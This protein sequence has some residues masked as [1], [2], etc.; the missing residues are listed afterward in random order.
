M[1]TCLNL[2]LFGSLILLIQSC[3]SVK[4]YYAPGSAAIPSGNNI[5]NASDLKYSLY[6]TGGVSLKGTSPVLKAIEADRQT[7]KSGLVLLG[8]VLSIDELPAPVEGSDASI[9]EEINRIKNLD[10]SFNDLFLIPGQKEWSSEKKV[11]SSAIRLLDRQLKDVR[12]KGRF[13]EPRKGCGTPE[14]VRIT[15]NAI[16]VLVDSQWAIE[17]EARSGEKMNGCELGNVIELKQAIKGIVQSHP[18]DHIIIATHHPIYA[19]G[20]TAGNYPISSHLIPLPVIGTIIT[21]IK[22]LVG[23]NQHFGHPAYE[24]YRSAFISA[25]D[26]CK[27]CIVVSGH[28]KNLQYF[29]NSG[30][31]YLIAGSG[32]KVGYARKGDKSGFSYMSRG[33]VRADV[34]QDGKLQVS[35]IALDDADKAEAGNGAG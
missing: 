27:N 31:H 20:K 13:I 26:G 3:A 25:I 9:S 35:F 30:E 23:S 22:S 2:F 33:F 5:P 14:A 15:D 1:K 24:A 19:N 4:P 18:T 7:S 6:L 34:L 17:S 8:D 11:T 10:A 21:G 32:D 12:D 28:E 16:L 29:E